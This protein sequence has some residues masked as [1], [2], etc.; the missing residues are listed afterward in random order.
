MNQASN[1]FRNLLR[2]YE[3]NSQK[4]NTF[5]LV[6]ILHTFANQNLISFEIYE[7]I[8]L[9]FLESVKMSSENC[10]QKTKD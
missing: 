6:L 5:I 1:S 4:E 3:I 10:I 8:V 2:R 7:H 9:S